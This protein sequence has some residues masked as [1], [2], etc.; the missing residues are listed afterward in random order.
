[1]PIA[2][3]VVSEQAFAAWV[4]AGEEEIRHAMAARPTDGGRGRRDDAP[5]KPTMTSEASKRQR[6]K[7]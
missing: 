2:V 5:M 1:M 6:S 7:D 3:R 4:E